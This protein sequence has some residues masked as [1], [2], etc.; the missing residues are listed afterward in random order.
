MGRNEMGYLAGMLLLCL[1]FYIGHITDH[2]LWAWIGI[3]LFLY[4]FFGDLVA[5]KNHEL[6]M[7]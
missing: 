2:T 7:S 5:K 3:L 6:Q 1:C 4:F